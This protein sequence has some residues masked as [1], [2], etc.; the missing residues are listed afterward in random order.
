MEYFWKENKRFVIAVAGGLAFLILYQALVLGKIRG[1]AELADRTR[2]SK[3]TEIERKM[4]Q[5]VPTEES[6]AVARKDRDLTRKVLAQMAPETA[7]T[8]PDRFQKPKSRP[9]ELKEYYDDLLIKLTDELKEKA[10]NGRLGF[11]PTLGMPDTVNEDTVPEMLLRLA[12]VDRL[13]TLCIDAECEKIESIN[14]LH[15]ADQ[16]E[17]SSKK[18]RFLTKYSVFIRFSG[19]ADAIFKVIHGAQKKGSYLAVTQ[20]DM[21]RPDATKDVFEAALGVALLKVDDKGELDAP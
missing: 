12:V 5:G 9:K 18:S 14:P 17:R 15:G 3:Q 10:T 8:V 16:D 1:A 11:P 21:S 4:A 2:R 7:F 6:L 20:F 13:S 19:R